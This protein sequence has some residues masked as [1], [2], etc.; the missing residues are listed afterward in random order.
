MSAIDTI[1]FTK[2]TAE[3]FFTILRGAGVS[4]LI[5][6]RL[7]NRSQLS[8]FAKSQDPDRARLPIGTAL[9]LLD[10]ER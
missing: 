7:N 4:H 1:G 5:D 8:G 6:I 2:K 3:A 9:E 10:L